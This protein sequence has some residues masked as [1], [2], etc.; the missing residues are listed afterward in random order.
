MEHWV[1]DNI[2]VAGETFREFVKKLYQ[3]NELVKGEFRLGDGRVELGR[4]TCPLLLLTAKNDHL[5]APEST[6]GIMPHVGS[7]DVKSMM[8]NAGHVGLVVGCKAQKTFWPEA[9]RWIADRSTPSGSACEPRALPDKSTDQILSTYRRRREI[10]EECIAVGSRSPAREEAVIRRSRA[11]VLAGLLANL[12]DD[13]D[14]VALSG[15]SGGAICA[16]LAWDG[17]RARATRSGPSAS[18]RGSGS[19]SSASD[20]CGPDRQSDADERDGPAGS[21]GPARGEPLPPPDLGR[22][23]VPRRSSIEYFDFEELRELARRPGAPIL[24]IG[25]VEVLSGHFELFTGEDLCVEC[26]M[27]SA[28]I[29]EMFRAVAGSRPGRV[30]GRPVLAESSHPRSHRSPDQRALG[31][32][33]Q[34]EHL[35]AGSDRDPRDPRPPQRAVRKPLDGAGAELHRDDQPGDRRRAG[36]TAPKFQPIHVSRIPLD[37]EL[38]YRSKLDRRPE[39]LEELREYGRTKSRWFLKERESRKYTM[40]PRHDLIERRS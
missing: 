15:T 20:P 16:A 24:Q 32:P 6:E 13:V 34:L 27:A 3:R 5:V 18:C 33:D 12:P 11:G 9:T 23:P 7:Q 38:G 4:I 28:A 30:L 40:E 25:A 22:G 17:L 37:R 2:P 36:S 35:R 1:N 10:W 29:P 14:V 26:L 31:D 8:I 21:H 19:R 39:F